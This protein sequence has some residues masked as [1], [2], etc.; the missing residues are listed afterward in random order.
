MTHVSVVVV[1]GH[2]STDI[3]VMDSSL[4]SEASSTAQHRNALSLNLVDRS[5][6]S[7]SHTSSIGI[8]GTMAII[9]PPKSYSSSISD[10]DRN[11]E[12]NSPCSII[13]EGTTVDDT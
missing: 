2:E 10:D 4:S 12:V 8:G 1:G 9:P 11:N 5:S 6:S 13:V 3:C 7:A